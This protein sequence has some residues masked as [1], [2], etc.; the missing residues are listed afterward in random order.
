MEQRG[1]VLDHTLNIEEK[2]NLRYHTMFLLF[3]KAIQ[4]LG[5]TLQNVLFLVSGI[6]YSISSHC[7]LTKFE[8]G[9]SKFR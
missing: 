8:L 5:L 7:V 2:R 9:T 6:L 1:A 4:H 3:A